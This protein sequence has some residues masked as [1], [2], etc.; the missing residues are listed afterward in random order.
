MRI[1]TRLFCTLALL[2]CL[3]SISFAGPEFPS[4]FPA[5][6]P[7]YKGCEVV[8]TMNFPD[9]QTV[10]LSCGKAVPDEVA[11]FY[12]NS[13]SADKWTTLMENKMQG[14]TLLMFEKD[15][16][17]MQVQVIEDNGVTQ[18]ALSYMQKSQ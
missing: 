7:M 15:P 11:E 6:F 8:Q 3:A 9:N 1:F 13:A 12:K 17:G 14:F 10:M 4:D 2:V 18:L 16:Q 5:A